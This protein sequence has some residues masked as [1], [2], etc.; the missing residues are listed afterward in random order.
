MASK[1]DRSRPH[2]GVKA[3]E[4]QQRIGFLPCDRVPHAFV[5]RN[6]AGAATEGNAELGWFVARRH[7]AELMGFSIDGAVFRDE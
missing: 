1:M 3:I 6:E 4:Q 5:L 7:R 2:E